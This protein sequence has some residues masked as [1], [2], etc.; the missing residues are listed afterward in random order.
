MCVGGGSTCWGFREELNRCSHRTPPHLL[1]GSCDRG[2][3]AA[4]ERS[5]HAGMEPAGRQV[6]AVAAAG[7]VLARLA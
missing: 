1:V 5:A 2:V 3:T 7:G 4:T 6:E